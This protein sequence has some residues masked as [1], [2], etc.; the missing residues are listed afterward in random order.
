MVLSKLPQSILPQS[1]LNDADLVT[2]H[3]WFNI[4]AIK[5]SDQGGSR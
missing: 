3:K 1:G 2:A 4:A 5:G